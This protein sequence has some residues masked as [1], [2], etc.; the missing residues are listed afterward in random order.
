[1]IT[2]RVP[3]DFAAIA[4]ATGITNGTIGH[5]ALGWVVRDNNCKSYYRV[6]LIDPPQ[7]LPGETRIT[8][9]NDHW[10]FHND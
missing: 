2:R 10:C 8:I 9:A 7:M 1:M 3:I 5:N 4:E 6:F